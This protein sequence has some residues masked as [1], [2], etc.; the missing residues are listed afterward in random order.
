M[1]PAMRPNPPTAPRLI[2]EHSHPRGMRRGQLEQRTRDARARTRPN[3]EQLYE[4]LL[5]PA[6]PLGE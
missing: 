1:R 4:L 2:R 5:G 3:T 6:I